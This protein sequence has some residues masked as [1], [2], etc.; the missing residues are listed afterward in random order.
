MRKT[1][2]LIFQN[3][4]GQPVDIKAIFPPMNKHKN[5]VIMAKAGAGMSF[6]RVCNERHQ[7]NAND[8]INGN[9]HDSVD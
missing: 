7:G 1:P 8:K 5:E 3:R 4:A 6:N 2:T 9:R